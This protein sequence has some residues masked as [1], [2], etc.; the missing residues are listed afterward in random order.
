M[1]FTRKMLIIFLKNVL[2]KP[3]LSFT[4]S[5]KYIKTFTEHM[6]IDY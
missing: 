3:R 5:L 4:K 2:S 1:N 6:K